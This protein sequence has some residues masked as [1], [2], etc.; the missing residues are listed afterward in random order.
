MEGS[1]DCGYGAGKGEVLEGM[2][3]TFL[4][5]K[6][7]PRSGSDSGEN[8]EVFKGVISSTSPTPNYAAGEGFPG[9]NRPEDSKSSLVGVPISRVQYN[10]ASDN[11]DSNCTG[12]GSGC[13]CNGWLGEEKCLPA[14]LDLSHCSGVCRHCDDCGC[15][16]IGCSSGGD[17]D[18]QNG[19]GCVFSGD[20]SKG[21]QNAEDISC[22]SNITEVSSPVSAHLCAL[23]V[24]SGDNHSKVEGSSSSVDCSRCGRDAEAGGLLDKMAVPIYLQVTVSYA[25]DMDSCP[26]PSPREQTPSPN[27]IKGSSPSATL[28]TPPCHAVLDGG[29]CAGQLKLLAGRSLQKP[30]LITGGDRIKV[31]VGAPGD[32][33]NTKHPIGAFSSEDHP[34]QEPRCLSRSFLSRQTQREGIVSAILCFPSAHPDLDLVAGGQVNID[35]ESKVE[36]FGCDEAIGSRTSED[37]RDDK[38]EHS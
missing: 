16:D 6:T 9:L 31:V 37:G 3:Q 20:D 29:L 38:S 25:P 7:V 32:S 10:S 36:S 33:D 2:S 13:S 14:A 35:L 26:A 34:V 17:Y 22:C 11:D 28:G 19:Y 15:D 18:Q 30:S 5:S 27:E 23:P 24:V 21:V 4:V 12:K 8:T 1:K